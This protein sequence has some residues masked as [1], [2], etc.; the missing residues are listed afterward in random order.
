MNAPILRS[1]DNP[2]ARTRELAQ[3]HIG[4]AELGWTDDDYRA[5]LFAK[6]GVRSAAQLDGARRKVFIEHLKQCGWK[7]HKAPAGPQLSKQQW[8]IR[9]LWKDLGK[10]GAL[11]DQSDAALTAFVGRL[12]GISEL[13]FLGTGDA[14]KVIEAL[15]GWLKRARAR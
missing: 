11:D 6:T 10:A 8:H 9:M 1:I 5:I 15:K 14:S 7:G 2:K 12:V 13:R 3:I 4:V